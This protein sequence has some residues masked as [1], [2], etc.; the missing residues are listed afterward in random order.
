MGR[1]PKIFD[2]PEQLPY[3]KHIII[4]Y[5]ELCYMREGGCCM[6]TS[7]FERKI[8]I[9]GQKSAEQLARVIASQPGNAF[10]EHP[11]SAQERDRSEQ[12]LK[13]CRLR[14]ER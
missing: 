12:L 3:N 10:S 11:Y 6:A 13:R 5:T 9:R 2:N 4:V 7:T 1:I 8:E 14:S